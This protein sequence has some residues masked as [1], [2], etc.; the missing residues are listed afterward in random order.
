MEKIAERTWRI[1]VE[2]LWVRR[3]DGQHFVSIRNRTYQA[4][5]PIPAERVEAWRGRLTGRAR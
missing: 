1:G 2:T 4:M 5:H 3:S